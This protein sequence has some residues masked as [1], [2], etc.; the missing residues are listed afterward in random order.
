MGRHHVAGAPG[1]T[2][3][4]SSGSDPTCWCRASWRTASN[5]RAIPYATMIGCSQLVSPMHAIW[6]RSKR[7]A[8]VRRRLCP[9]G[10]HRAPRSVPRI[11]ANGTR[12]FTTPSASP[13]STGDRHG[14]SSA[15]ASETVTVRDERD[16]PTERGNRQQSF[17]DEQRS[18]FLFIPT[19]SIATTVADQGNK[20]HHD[21]IVT[22]VPAVAQGPST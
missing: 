7:R 20:C 9:T 18:R 8:P 10:A 5:V 22:S 16:R 17:H 4:R 13:P 2:S 14:R 15:T 12:T 19:Q 3:G 6:M 11:A 21:T 1:F